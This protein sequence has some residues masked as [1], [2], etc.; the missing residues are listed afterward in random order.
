MVRL[1][2]YILQLPRLQRCSNVNNSLQRVYVTPLLTHASL[3]V[4]N[5][6]AQHTCAQQ[7]LSVSMLLAVMLITSCS[8]MLPFRL[9]CCEPMSCRGQRPGDQLSTL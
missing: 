8:C 2:N 3:A 5:G 4:H 6:I 1:Y 7:C 9:S